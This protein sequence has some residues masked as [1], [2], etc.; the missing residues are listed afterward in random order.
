MVAGAFVMP[1]ILKTGGPIMPYA[2]I[3]VVVAIAVI[4]AVAIL[5]LTHLINPKRSGAVKSAVYESGV[6]PVTDARRRFNVRFYI[7]AILFLLFDVEVVILWPWALVYYEAATAKTDPGV[8]T[9]AAEAGMALFGKGFILTGATLFLV[10]L[11]VGYI[12]E[13]KKGLF[14]WD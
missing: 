12:Y 4:M 8:A 10:L 7:V 11:L 13:W 9:Q 2:S 3:L 5:V 6:P 14:R 1:E